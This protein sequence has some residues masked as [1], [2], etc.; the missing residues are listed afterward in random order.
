MSKDKSAAAR[1]G[2]VMGSDSDLAVMKEAAEVLEEFGVPYEMTVAS[3][4]R[5]P[6]RAARYAATAADRGLDVIIAGAG[7]A[8]HLAGVMAAGCTLPVIAVP[9]ASSP[10]SGFDA[11]LSSAQMP[12]G[13][14]VAV[15]SVGSWGARNA[16]LLAVQIIARREAPLREALARHKASMAEAVEAKARALE[17]GAHGRS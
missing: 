10:L 14:P 11:L 4:H 1:V 2:I 16:G 5:S 3:A 6:D 9:L 13:V 15:V 8:A 7:G 12:P 17:K